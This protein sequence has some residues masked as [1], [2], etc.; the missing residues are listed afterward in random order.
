MA[1]YSALFICLLLVIWLF[2]RDQRLRPMTSGALW[3]VLVW[4][5]IIGSR[6]V[7]AWFGSVEIDSADVLIDGSPL[8]RNVFLTLIVSGAVLLFRRK[9]DWKSI[10]VTNSWFFAF[11]IYCGIS[12]IWSDFP[13]VSFKRWIKELGNVIMVMIVITEKSPIQAI[14]AVFARYVYSVIPLSV[15]LILFFPDIGTSIDADSM[16]TACIGVTVNKNSLGV[17]TFI[18]C[19]FTVWEIAYISDRD[20]KIA[21]ITDSVGRVMLLF[22]MT[23]LIYLANSKTALICLILGVGILLSMKI[24]VFKNQSRFLGTYSLLSGFLI[25][26]IC[27]VPGIRD[28]FLRALGRDVTLTG[29]TDMW[30]DLWRE[31]INPLLGTGYQSFWLG[32]RADFLWEKYLFHPIQAHNGYLETYLNGGLIGMLL[33]V[34][35]TV[36]TGSNLKKH[37]LLESKFTVLLQ[38]IFVIAVFYNLTEAMFGRLTLFWVILIIAALYH[39]PLID[40]VSRNKFGRTRARIPA[41]KE[42]K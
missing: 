20:G 23:W 16:D 18:C 9:P 33:L 28:A 21:D 7:S 36:K 8:D 6:F 30:A 34:A 38:T 10:L 41:I 5:T 2:A 13:F 31:P 32:N 39:P 14:R 19:L 26:Y 27:S 4:I 42:L 15:V 24:P 11:F 25:F 12:I 40:D 35:M 22:M 17:I 29:R 3:I 1:K 37:M